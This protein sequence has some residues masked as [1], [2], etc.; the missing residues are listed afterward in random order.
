MSTVFVE[1]EVDSRLASRVPEPT[2]PM[3][4][5]QFALSK[6]ASVE[7]IEKLVALAE[8]EQAKR[9]KRAFEGSVAAFKQNPPAVLRNK[10]V[11]FDT[12]KG[13]TS[14]RHASLDNVCAQLDP[15][16][17]KHGL[18]AR[19][20]T[21]QLD[22]GLIRV[23]CILSHVEGHSEETRLQCTADISGGKNA[24]QAVGSTVTYLERYTLLAACGIAVQNADDDG[25]AA[26]N[27][28]PIISDEQRK[29]LCDLMNAK[30]ADFD[31]FCEFFKIPEIGELPQS[32]FTQAMSMVSQ[33]KGAK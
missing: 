13:R 32:K 24:I 27:A 21:E 8:R 7:Q 25:L 31:K 26:G 2:D 10:L 33:K 1:A 14:Y 22:G 16:L 3:S 17:A 15:A 5:V 6:G 11:E 4:L 12:S 19:W 30:R 9:A 18:S 20:K 28:D 23:T 29:Q